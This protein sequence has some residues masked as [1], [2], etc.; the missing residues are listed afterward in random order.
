MKKTIDYPNTA[1][2]NAE[3]IVERHLQ[4]VEQKAHRDTRMIL[5]IEEAVLELRARA[6]DAGHAPSAFAQYE[7]KLRAGLRKSLGLP[8]SVPELDPKVTP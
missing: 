7:T 8:E 6:L 2:Q 3:R 1:R 4:K 5:K